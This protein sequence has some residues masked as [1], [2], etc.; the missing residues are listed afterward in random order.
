MP[1]LPLPTRPHSVL[2]AALLALVLWTLSRPYGGLAHDGILYLGQALLH[3]RPE[4]MSKDIF[5]E[6]GSQ[7][8]FSLFSRLLAWL[9]QRLDLPLVQVLVLTACHA[10]LL[11]ASW[12]L[13]TPI[14]P[15]QRWLGLAALAVLSHQYGGHAIFAFAERFVTARTL[16]EPLALL[17]LVACTRGRVRLSL[18]T[19]VACALVHPLVALGAATTVWVWLVF[20]DRRWLLGLAVVPAGLLLGAIGVAPLDQLLRRYDPTWWAI[21]ETVSRHVLV[22]TWG[23][24]DWSLL[25]FDMGL[26]ALAARWFPPPLARVCHAV[27][28]ACA[29]LVTCSLLVSD[30]LHNVLITQLQLWRVLWIAHLLALALLPALSLRAWSQG[31]HGRMLAIALVT[32]A[33]AVYARWPAGWVFLLWVLL[34]LSLGRLPGAVTPAF[35]RAVSLASGVVLV[36]L[37]AAVFQS[38][39]EV[40]T[41]RRDASTLANAVLLLVTIPAISLPVAAVLLRLERRRAVAAAIVLLAGAAAWGVTHWDRRPDMTRAIESGLHDDHPFRHHLPPHAQVMWWRFPAAT[42]VLLQ[43]PNYWSGTQ[44]SGLLF[45]RDTAVEF[46]RRHRLFEGLGVQEHLCRAMHALN[47]EASEGVQ[48]SSLNECV[49]TSELMRKFCRADRGPTHLVF[50]RRF[51]VA[52]AAWTVPATAG[53]QRTWYLYDC[54]DFR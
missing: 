15:T 40:L 3:L 30:H 17:S 1:L 37:S 19:L 11:V 12:L 28:I 38:H 24:E 14:A 33:T 36:A 44:G 13:M 18:A 20:H 7:D 9:Y 27:L 52:L 35:A 34:T 45:N 29:L 22:S 21:V 25:T 6:F 26:L 32:A 8:R 47:A 54:A 31:P 43:R 16:A 46:M 4:A 42:W 49:P 51:D 41:A 10:A 48:D 50:E 2:L 23:H 53:P 39:H 5:F